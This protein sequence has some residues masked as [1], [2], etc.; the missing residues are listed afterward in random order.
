MRRFAQ[1]KLITVND[2]YAILGLSHGATKD[3]IK[4][5]WR[6]LAS[7]NHPDTFIDEEDRRI[8]NLNLQKINN[9]N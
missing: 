3:D 1:L 4:K 2:P 5:T 9:A 7:R 8:A 6:M